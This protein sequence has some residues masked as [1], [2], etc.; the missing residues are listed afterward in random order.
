VSG[1]L[2]VEVAG[3]QLVLLPER[4]LFYP[5]AD[6]LLI[7][8]A[9]WGKAAA[10]QAHF[11]PVPEGSVQDDLKRLDAMLART[12]AAHLIVLGDLLHGTVPLDTAVSEQVISWR[13]RHTALSVTLV[14]GN[15]DRI[16]P[17]SGWGM[18]PFEGP[19]QMGGL[20]LMHQ[21]QVGEGG[22]TLAG[23]LHP[24]VWMYGKGKQR[25]RLP[26]FW[27]GPRVGVLPAFGSFT[28]SSVVTPAPSDGVYAVTGEAVIPVR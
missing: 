4:G 23:H 12:G 2:A 17:P 16:D 6:A 5:R 10:F 19:V 15:H 13:G 18:Q 24:A 25:I 11:I 9:H 26:C 21:P 3:E 14:R 1:D 27:F 7:A 28:G 20:T 8:D 22:Y